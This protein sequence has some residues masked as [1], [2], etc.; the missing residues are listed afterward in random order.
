MNAF[1]TDVEEVNFD[2]S[3]AQPTDLPLMNAFNTEAVHEDD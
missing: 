3:S 2:S 1:I